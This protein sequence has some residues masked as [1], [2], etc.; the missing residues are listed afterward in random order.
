M[1]SIT[2]SDRTCGFILDQSC[3]TY[4]TTHYQTHEQFFTTFL[5]G[6][7]I[8]HSIINLEHLSR[9]GLRYLNAVLPSEDETPNKYL[10]DGLHGVHLNL[11]SRYSLNETVFDITE[12]LLKSTLVSRIHSKTGLLGYPPDIAF[13]NLSL[14]PQFTN[15]KSTS[16]AIIDLD[17]FI[18]RQ[19]P[20]DFE[21]TKAE[22]VSL[23]RYIKQVF[24]MTTTEHAKK[25]WE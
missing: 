5:D 25:N 16:H 2:K 18:E 14:M 8:I 10:V 6:L 22:L 3:L 24:D 12:R 17:H 13:G 20:I 21:Q 9:L 7:K 19:M 4:H 15:N 1:W 23:H 11:A